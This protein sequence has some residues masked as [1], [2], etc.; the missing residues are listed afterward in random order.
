MLNYRVIQT[1][2]ETPK[3]GLNVQIMLQKGQDRIQKNKFIT[4]HIK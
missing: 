1:K 3:T 4:I 2:Q